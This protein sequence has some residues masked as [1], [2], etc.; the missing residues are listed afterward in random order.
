MFGWKRVLV[1]IDGVPSEE[2]SAGLVPPPPTRRAA[3]LAMQL[4]ASSGAQLTFLNVT[5][6]VPE[7]YA[8]ATRAEAE[9]LV[10]T[11]VQEAAQR[12]IPAAGQVATGRAWIEIIREVQRGGHQVVVAGSRRQSAVRRMLLGTTGVKLL[13]SC[14]CPV[15]IVRPDE[16]P[17]VGTVIVADD[18]TPVG[19]RCLDLGV[20]AA[21]MLDARLLVLHAL[22][23]PLEGPMRHMGTPDD[24][25]EAYRAEIRSQ[26]EKTLQEHLSAT[27]YRTITQGTRTEVTAGQ[28]AL[29]IEEAIAEHA[30]NLLVM[31]TV[32]RGGIPGLLIGN[33]A[34]RLLPVVNCSLLAVKPDDF[35]CPIA[36]N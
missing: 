33:T 5:A 36:P 19:A 15:W 13:R 17:D 3:D 16:G 34:E 23:Y 29:V 9:R 2:S 28:P 20:A 35:V 32:A 8:A 24:Q 30:A 10:D 26:A 25:L 6:E 7:Q 12:Q 27:D 22:Q 31:G 1:A 21:R 18:L 11:L 4:A 14:P